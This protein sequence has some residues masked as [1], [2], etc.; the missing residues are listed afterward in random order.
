MN[1]GEYYQKKHPEWKVM[2]IKLTKKQECE[3]R[4]MV[5]QMTIAAFQEHMAFRCRPRPPSDRIL[6]CA[7]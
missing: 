1:I 3:L 6:D 4:E 7:S 2:T 5:N